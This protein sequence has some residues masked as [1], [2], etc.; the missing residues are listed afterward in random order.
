M[1]PH[2]FAHALFVEARFLAPELFFEAFVEILFAQFHMGR[3]PPYA[4]KM[5]NGFVPSTRWAVAA[6]FTG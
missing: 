6:K 4:G 5:R 3:A 1:T 2:H